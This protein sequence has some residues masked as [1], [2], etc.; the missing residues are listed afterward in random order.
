MKEV[1]FYMWALRKQGVVPENL[2]GAHL[3]ED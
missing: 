2:K 3:L 1:V